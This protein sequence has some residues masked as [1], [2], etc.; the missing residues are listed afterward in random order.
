[1]S[2]TAAIPRQR[3]TLQELIVRLPELGERP[4]VGLRGELGSRWWSYRRLYRE[5]LRAA[6]LLASR[7]VGHGDHLLLWGPNAPEWVA[8]FLAAVWRG[9][10]VVPLDDDASPELAARI[11][12]EVGARLIVVGPDRATAGVGVPA[13]DL[14]ALHRDPELAEGGALRLPVAAEDLVLVYFTSGTTAAPRGVVI[15]H[16]NLTSQLARFRR[17]RWLVRRVPFRIMVLAPLSHIQG[18]LLGICIPFAVGLSALYTRSLHPGQLIRAI[19]DERLTILSTVP[20]ALHTLGFEIQRRPYAGVPLGERIA[21][22]RIRFLRRHFTFRA[23][24]ALLGYRF[25]VI[26]VG[27]APLPAEDELFWRRTGC[28]VVQ[29]YGLTETTAVVSINRPLLGPV[30]SIGR[31]LAHQEVR[32]ADDGEILV[33]GPNVTPGYHGGG[34]IAADGFLHT[35]DVGRL[36]HRRRLYFV[37][38][39]KDVIVTGE[40]FNV[41]PGDVE[42][43]LHR[44]PGVRDAVVCAADRSGHAEVHAVLLLARGAEPAMAVGGAN[45]SLQPFQRAVSWSVWPEPDFPRTS[46]LKPRRAEVERRLPELRAAAAP[47][48]RQEPARLTL[49]DVAGE[50]DRERRMDLLVRYLA[51]GRRGEGAAGLRLVADLGLSS[52]D[53]VELLVR[54]ESRCQVALDDA[55]LPGET[56]VGDLQALVAGAPAA[57]RRVP[58]QQVAWSRGWLGGL[59]RAAVR[60][61]VLGLWSALCARVTARTT[62]DAAPPTGPVVLAVAPHRTWLDVL[63]VCAALPAPQR[64]RAT[65]VTDRGFREFFDPPPGTRRSTRLLIAA[66]YYLLMPAAFRFAIVPRFGGTRDGLREACRL[67]G[68]SCAAITFPKGFYYSREDARRHDPGAALIALETGLPIVPVWLEGNDAL[69]ARPRL[70]RPPVRVTFGPPVAADPGLDAAALAA[71]VEAAFAAMAPQFFAEA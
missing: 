52:L 15:S 41:H 10:V 33:R 17:W 6:A 27:G 36:D 26:F 61:L 2:A 16:G 28:R 50:S 25:W 29:G 8:F 54:A 44:Q 59:V 13:V 67:L 66:S 53:V 4:A 21:R 69:A 57:A 34:A 24:R 42:A 70:R 40:G 32:L 1:M 64:R 71:R 48:R 38:R 11:A 43:A 22:A 19:R 23:V 56:T 60:P 12:R 5:T 30:G 55:A 18:M 65:F 49:A 39:K 37:G 7:G 68:R 62:G 45:A 9:A 35:G 31:P 47:A 58:T 14:Y 63:A 46:L 20:R 51:E 3:D